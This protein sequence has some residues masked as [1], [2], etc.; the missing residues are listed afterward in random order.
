MPAKWAVLEE[1]KI[2]I[3]ESQ[4]LEFTKNNDFHQFAK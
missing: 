4:N 3:L 2:N 1:L